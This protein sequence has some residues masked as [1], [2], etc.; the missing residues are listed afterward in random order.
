MKASESKDKIIAI[1]HKRNQLYNSRSFSGN[2]DQLNKAYNKQKNNFEVHPIIARN[3][4][5]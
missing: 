4:H 3:I 1:S 5:W 2:W